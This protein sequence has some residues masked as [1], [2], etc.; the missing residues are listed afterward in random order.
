MG[1]LIIFL[2]ML[3]VL[4]IYVSAI[5]YSLGLNY[6][7]L[8]T[9]STLTDD[10]GNCNLNAT[11]TIMY[12]SAV[13]D[14][15]IRIGSGTGVA[16]NLSCGTVPDVKTID[17]W[18][19]AHTQSATDG[20]LL[21]IYDVDNEA[22]DYILIDML[23]GSSYLKTQVDGGGES[24]QSLSSYGSPDTYRHIVITMNVNGSTTFWVNGVSKDY[25]ALSDRPQSNWEGITGFETYTESDNIYL[26]SEV[27]DSADAL[28]SYNS[29]SGVHH[30]FP[31]SPPDTSSPLINNVKLLSFI[32]D[33]VNSTRTATPTIYF[34][35]NDTTGVKKVRCGNDSTMSFDQAGDTRNGSFVSD[36]NWT[37]TIPVSDKLTN[38]GVPQN[39]YVWGLDDLGNNH[40]VWNNT[41][42]VT[43]TSCECPSSGDWSVKC[44]EECTVSS[45]CDMSGN[46][47]IL[48]GVG[49]FTIEA[50]IRNIKNI[51][52][53]D[54]CDIFKGAG[55]LTLIKN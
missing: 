29:G 2:F 47:L 23:D 38:Y 24:S 10:W 55:N 50:N 13:R 36:N 53:P 12:D 45:D 44:S 35:A 41:I 9:N 5:E 49:S 32:T 3:I 33:G 14:T 34:G 22:G 16:Q 7:R 27:Y 15:G 42:A 25:A 1:K 46:N 20:E 48:N 39:I 6:W 21:K 31:E 11:G 30:L 51:T 8:D 52:F 26:S 40:S 28:E 37:C 54:T 17:M 19:E 43:I 18:Y 4:S